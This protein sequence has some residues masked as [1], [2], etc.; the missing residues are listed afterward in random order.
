MGIFTPVDV[1]RLRVAARG[2]PDAAFL[3]EGFSGG[4]ALGV[5]ESYRLDPSKFKDRPARL[6]LLKKLE[7]EVSLGRIIGPFRD[8]PIPD[9]FVSPLSLIPKPNSDKWRLIFNL[10]HPP[11][12]SVNDNILDEKKTVQYCSVHDVGQRLASK[13]GSSAWLAKIDLADAYRIVPIRREDWKF[14]GICVNGQYYIDRMLPMGASSSCQLFQR[15]S[16]GL[17]SMALKILPPNVDIFNYLDDFLLIAGTQHI[18]NQATSVFQD[19]CAQVGVPIANH[20]TIR[21][22]KAL[23]FLGLGIDT[24]RLSLFIPEAKR[25]QGQEK[26]TSFLSSKVPRV[27]DWQSIAGFLNHLAQVAVAGRIFLSSTYGSMTNILSQ[28][29]QLRRAISPE[30]RQDLQVWFALLNNPPERPFRI[31]DSCS[32]CPP[33]YTDA[34]TSVGFGAV[35]GSQWFYGTW[36]VGRVCNIAV[37]ELFP[38]VLALFLLNDDVVDRTV[39]VYTDNSAL[40]S[41][42]SKLYSGN[43]PLRKLIRPLVSLCLSR[44]L[45]ITAAHVPGKENTGP[46]MLSRGE[47]DKFRRAFPHVDTMPMHIPAQLLGWLTNLIEWH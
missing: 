5:K 26:L 15:I 19:M 34:S 18:C 12:A 4:F 20:K 27:R 31:L 8:R 24:V 38:I 39:E 41:I 45:S 1:E 23:T 46:D 9:L 37:L 43:R 28:Q 32:A 7:E 17:K 36:P 10:S 13:Y 40:V 30:V 22:C 11:G 16:D 21:A 25:V 14:L 2:C 44:N 35:W 29:K 42:I 6:A 47:V 3:I 33:L